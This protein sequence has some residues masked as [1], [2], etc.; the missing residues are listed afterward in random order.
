M[1]ATIVIA[2][3]LLA[4][5]P[6]RAEEKPSWKAGFAKANITPEK[7]MWLAG[8]GGR[9]RP[10][11][12]KLHDFWIKALALEDAGGRRVVLLTSDLC[13]MPKWMDE[14]VCEKLKKTHKLERDQVRLTN[15]HNHCAP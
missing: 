9:D 10:A 13:G 5:G 1:R 12:G 6:V 15:S 7:P 3:A 14:S 11:E 4:A 2:L 8:Y